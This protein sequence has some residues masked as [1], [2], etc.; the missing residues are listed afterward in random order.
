MGCF[1]Q[2]NS[3]GGGGQDF[4]SWVQANQAAGGGL[5]PD[6]QSTLNQMMNT[7]QG[8]DK[9]GE[10]PDQTKQRIASLFPTMNPGFF[11]SQGDVNSIMAQIGLA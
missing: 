9:F 8:L 11:R 7:Q 1:D 3:S 5:N 2:G 4:Y 6:A 10:M